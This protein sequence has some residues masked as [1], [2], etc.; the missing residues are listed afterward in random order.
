MVTKIKK[1]VIKKEDKIY[2]PGY[3]RFMKITQI[4][5][6]LRNEKV[7]DVYIRTDG[8]VTAFNSEG[9]AVL[10]CQGYIL[11][12]RVVK[13]LKER[14]SKDTNFHFTPGGN[15]AMQIP[16]ALLAVELKEKWD[17]KNKKS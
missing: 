13:N 5:S 12:S 16:L 14:C 9:M 3:G 15:Y 4:D 6:K 2:C 11:D 10:D 8:Y 17:K 1:D 7:A